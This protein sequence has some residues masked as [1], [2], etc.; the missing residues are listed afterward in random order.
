[1][2]RF[3]RNS[4]KVLRASKGMSL[5]DF[6]E[7]VGGNVTRQLVSQWEN[8]TQVPS[9]LSLLKIVNAHKVP[10][11]IFFESDKNSSGFCAGKQP[12]PG[13]PT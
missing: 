8:G 4:I 3:S 7:S 10:F 12:S 13:G 5:K 11:D 9:V 1:M 2:Q 6:A